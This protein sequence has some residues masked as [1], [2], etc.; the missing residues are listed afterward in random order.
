[1]FFEDIFLFLF[2]EKILIVVKRTFVC[3]FAILSL[4]P[5]SRKMTVPPLMANA[6]IF[7]S[8]QDIPPYMTQ[9]VL[10]YAGD[11]TKSWSLYIQ[12]II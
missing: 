6:I 5:T 8:P 4:K 2:L 12:Y 7:K 1:M 3:R 10:G 9:Q 11:W